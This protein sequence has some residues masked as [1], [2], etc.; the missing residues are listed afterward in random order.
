METDPKKA[1]KQSAIAKR[2]VT[3]F[4][5]AQGLKRSLPAG[6]V[7]KIVERRENGTLVVLTDDGYVGHVKS[8]E[9]SAFEG[10]PAS[11][12]KVDEKEIW[13]RLRTVFD[14]EI[15][16]SVVDLGL[17]Y[18]C[19]IVGSRVEIRMTL[20]APG[21]PVG[22][23]IRDEIET[24]L[25]HVPGVEDVSVT[26]VWDPPWDRNKISDAAKLQLGLL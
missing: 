23:D 4:A 2:P 3:V 13:N 9:A 1:E 17:V 18:E 8:S 5:F 26:F 7:V 22:D 6:S 19:K 20:T 25:L 24:K 16:V 10:E 21:C 12:S 15:P 11:A 14:P